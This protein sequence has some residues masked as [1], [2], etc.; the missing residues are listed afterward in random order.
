MLRTAS[1]MEAALWGAVVGA[2][3]YDGTLGAWALEN[4]AVLALACVK[5]TFVAWYW[6]RAPAVVFGLSNAIPVEGAIAV[7]ALLNATL[8]RH[9]PVFHDRPCD[10]SLSSMLTGV[11][12]STV[13]VHACT[14]VLLLA[15][16]A[17]HGQC[18]MDE[19]GARAYDVRD[20]VAALSLLA[21]SL[22]CVAFRLV[23]DV[24]FYATHRAQ[25]AWPRAYSWLH[26]RHH[27][28]RRTSLR[29]NFQFTPLD[30]L[31]EG[32]L[33]SLVAGTVLYAL[34]DATPLEASMLIG[35]VQW[36][37][38]GS[39]AAKDVDSVTAVPPLAP[40]YNWSVLKRFRPAALRTHRH[41]RFHAAHHR[42]VNG[43][44]GISPWLDWLCGTMV[45]Q[46]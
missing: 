5:C 43:N 45:A 27:R 35:Y 25:H 17:I 42:A 26:A 3:L 6:V 37:Q 31:L 39:H 21:L 24:V 38:I 34:C 41:I 9:V 20:D 44:Y 8:Y 16:C 2:G 30:L 19:D 29:T 46:A 22:K 14:I 12:H 15:M 23:S 28:H 13:P 4:G 1:W 7:Q 10:H 32:S 40:L 18:E 36:Y 11:L 33:P